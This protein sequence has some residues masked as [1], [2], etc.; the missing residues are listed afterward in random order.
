[1]AK[2]NKKLNGIITQ[3]KLVLVKFGSDIGLLSFVAKD[4]F[5][6]TYQ[7]E[8]GEENVFWNEQLPIIDFSNINDFMMLIGKKF[9]PVIHDWD[10]V[11]NYVLNNY[12]Q[13][14]KFIS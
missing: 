9:D 6:Y 4:C 1:M 8:S 11:A 14:K 5:A 12:K 10:F 2:Q 7:V 13:L 3:L